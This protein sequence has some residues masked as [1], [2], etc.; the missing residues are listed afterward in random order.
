MREEFSDIGSV[1]ALLADARERIKESE[2]RSKEAMD[3]VEQRL[4]DR[5]DEQERLMS[6]LNLDLTK[7]VPFLTNLQKA[8]ENKKTLTILLITSFITNLATII[9]SIFVWFVKS[10]VIK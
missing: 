10:G 6:S 1:K 3:R 9:I 2:D 8:D 7:W 5:L 4:N